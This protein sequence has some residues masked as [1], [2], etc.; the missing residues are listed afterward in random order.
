MTYESPVK[1]FRDMHKNPDLYPDDFEEK[2]DLKNLKTN[3]ISSPQI[4]LER[5]EIITSAGTIFKDSLTLVRNAKLLPE[6]QNNEAEAKIIESRREL[7]IGYLEKVLE[8]VGNYIAQVNNLQ[9]QKITSYDDVD[10]YQEAVGSS[11]VLRRSYHN[12]LISDLKITMRLININ[13][14]ADYPE[15][16][17][18]KEEGMMQDRKGLSSEQLKA[19]MD[20][21]EYYH[22][23]FRVGG[24]I[25]FS[26]APKD[27][28]GE[29][30]YIA[31]WALKIYIDLSILNEKIKKTHD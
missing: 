24:F 22:F 27:P 1:K 25:D 29:R 7:I 23:P 30:E 5:P 4:N 28:I 31:S 9:L 10:K 20:Q 2:R 19:I 6:F 11:D 18:L 15:A 13:F 3:D 12:K 26:K 14:S 8:D 21:R 16:M 17:R